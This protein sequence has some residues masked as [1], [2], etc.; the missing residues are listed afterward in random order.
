MNSL[1]S[2]LSGITFD[3]ACRYFFHIWTNIYFSLEI[4]LWNVTQCAAIHFD[5]C[6]GLFDQRL[7]LRNI[8]QLE[9]PRNEKRPLVG[10]RS[11]SLAL[12]FMWWPWYRN[13]AFQLHVYPKDQNNNKKFKIRNKTRLKQYLL[14]ANPESVWTVSPASVLISAKLQSGERNSSHREVPYMVKTE[15]LVVFLPFA[16]AGLSFR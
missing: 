7:P 8:Q 16:S 3:I 14:S 10:R 4:A 13:T 2:N 5:V 11:Y 15:L 9:C 6:S 12:E 1:I